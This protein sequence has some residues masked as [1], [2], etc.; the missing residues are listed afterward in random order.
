MNINVAPGTRYYKLLNTNEL[1]ED[2][3]VAF[4]QSVVL[5]ILA[6]FAPLDEDISQ[7][8]ERLRQLEEKRTSIISPLR[9]IPAEVLSGIFSWT[10]PLA[11]EL[12]R[13]KKFCMTESPW[14][15]TH[16]CRHWRSI[17]VSN[18]SLCSLISITYRRGLL[19][20]SPFPARRLSV[21]SYS[22]LFN[23]PAHNL[24]RYQLECP[25]PTHAR[26]LRLPKNVVEAC[27]EV[28][29]DEG[30]WIDSGEIE[31]GSLP[32]Y[33]NFRS[34]SSQM[35]LQV[36]QYTSSLVSRSLC[37]LRTLCLPGLPG[38]SPTAEILSKAPSIID[39]PI[40][41]PAHSLEEQ[42]DALM[43]LLTVADHAGPIVIYVEYPS[44]AVAKPTSTAPSIQRWSNPGG[45]QR[46]AHSD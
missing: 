40:V 44:F 25:W 18:L 42:V 19:Q 12:A 41:I 37:P 22:I 11:E 23:F 15:L 4:V 35:K 45:K 20:G 14:V 34:I 36:F 5:N 30:P 3:K 46:V 28:E 13:R 21:G 29:F 8:H 33:I 17:R 1:P 6:R 16:V 43:S 24:T 38:S 26:I 10:L 31:L 39:L 7:L 9:R 2:S 27:I 32:P